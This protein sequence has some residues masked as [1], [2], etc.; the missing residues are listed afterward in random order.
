MQTASSGADGKRI[1][2]SESPGVPG[3][4]KL[5]PDV[6]IWL[7]WRYW[8]P[9]NYYVGVRRIQA[10]LIKHKVAQSHEHMEP[11]GRTGHAA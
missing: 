5:Y 3:A 7:A 9:Q 2:V 8:M 6:E 4:R 10:W 11:R 1:P